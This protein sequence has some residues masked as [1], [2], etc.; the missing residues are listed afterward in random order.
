M[1]LFFERLLDGLR[2][3]QLPAPKFIRGMRG[4]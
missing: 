3:L 1:P 2:H 4:R